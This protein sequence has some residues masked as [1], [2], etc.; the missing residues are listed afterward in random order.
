MEQP[1]LSELI[2]LGAVDTE[3]FNRTFFPAA[4]RLAPPVFA[5]RLNAAL[6]NPN[7]RLLNLKVFRGGTKTTRLRMFTAKRIAYGISR[8]ILY[9]GASED[10]AKRSIQ[11]VRSNI[12]PKMGGDGVERATPFA[13]TFGLTITKKGESELRIR[14]GIDGHDIWLVGVGITGN[15]RGINFDNYRPDLI[16]LDDV[17]T[18]ES[19]ATAAQREK[20]SD[21]IMGAVA[22]SLI[23]KVEEPNAKLVMLQTPLD[24]DDASGRAE[25]SREWHTEEFSCWTE[26]TKHAPVEEQISSWEAMFPTATLRQQKID[27]LHDNRYSVFAREMECKIVSAES[28]AFRRDWL[29]RYDAPPKS[30][31]CIIAVDPVPPPSPTQMASGLKTK[32]YEAI[33]VVARH[34]GAYHVLDYAMHRGHEPDWT[35]AK[36]F[37]YVQRFR[38]QAVV[39]EMVAAQRYLEF[40]LR[41]EME[42]RRIYVAVKPTEIGGRSKFA[43][44]MASLTGPAS[45]GKLFC[46]N[47]H[48]ELIKQFESYGVGY[49]G[50]DD[51]LEAVANAVA[52][53]TNPFLELAADEFD[54]VTEEFPLR[55]VCP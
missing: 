11:W 50:N 8:T 33:A 31:V 43:R 44:I 42:R 49:K 29:R 28:A 41:K 34:D 38:P 40:M 48:H 9:V 30:G 54:D 19:T 18:D 35:M 51:L 27:A 45:N 37:E 7:Y 20:L 12:E 52:E 16:L 36:I 24:E 15:I 1:T 53:L 2:Q 46:S 10:H 39:I 47:E 3:F 32:D 17:L 14:H 55:Q 13:E 4:A 5:P 21:L 22:N 25:K 23:S 6:E 26:E